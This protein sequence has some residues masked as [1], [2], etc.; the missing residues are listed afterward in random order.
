MS[1]SSIERYLTV[2]GSMLSFD[3]KSREGDRRKK[4]CCSFFASETV[5]FFKTE[6]DCLVRALIGNLMWV[7]VTL[8]F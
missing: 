3:G 4:N 1:P 8:M 2:Y 5:E 7:C 6:L